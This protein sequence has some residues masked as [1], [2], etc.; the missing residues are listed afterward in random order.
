MVGTRAAFLNQR[1]FLRVLVNKFG[2]KDLSEKKAISDDSDGKATTAV[3]TLALAIEGDSTKLP[4]IRSRSDLY[5]A[6]SKIASDAQVDDCLLSAELL[7]APEGREYLS[8]DEV[9]ADY[10]DLIPL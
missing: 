3:V 1:S 10:P 6:L 2:G 8:R 5:E 7:W 4:V 9:Y